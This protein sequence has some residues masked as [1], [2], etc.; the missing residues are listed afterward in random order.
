MP[1]SLISHLI[2]QT[3]F[4]SLISSQSALKPSY[5]GHGAVDNNFA[6]GPVI[7]GATADRARTKHKSAP[8]EIC[9]SAL[10]AEP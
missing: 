7:C 9:L 4:P 8:T 10:C 1:Q 2:L 5:D 3:N 6:D